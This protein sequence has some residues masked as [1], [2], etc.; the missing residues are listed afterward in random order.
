MLCQEFDTFPVWAFVLLKSPAAEVYFVHQPAKVKVRLSPRSAVSMQSVS[1]IGIAIDGGSPATSLFISGLSLA[2]PARDW[3]QY[4]AVRLDPS[5]LVV[6][7]VSES[8]VLLDKYNVHPHSLW[9][10]DCA[11]S[12]SALAA[13]GLFSFWCWCADETVSADFIGLD[14]E[15]VSGGQKPDVAGKSCCFARFGLF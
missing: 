1:D 14:V 13:L 11:C 4:E 15:A 9:W 3:Q 8:E 10:R 2:I 7:D 6:N 12:T 5:N